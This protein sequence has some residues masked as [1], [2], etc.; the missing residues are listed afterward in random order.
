MEIEIK[1]LEIESENEADIDSD[2]EYLVEEVKIIDETL[3][4]EIVHFILNENASK[5]SLSVLVFA[6]LKFV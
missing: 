1:E 3:I 2:D 6:I 4:S 5:R